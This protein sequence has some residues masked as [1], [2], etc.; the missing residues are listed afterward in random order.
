MMKVDNRPVFRFDISDFKITLKEKEK[1]D[2]QYWET[3]GRPYTFRK[4]DANSDLKN[5]IENDIMKLQFPSTRVIDYMNNVFN[6]YKKIGVGFNV[7][8]LKP[9]LRNFLIE[10]EV[11]ISG[12]E[13]IK[14]SFKGEDIITTND[15]ETICGDKFY[16]I[17]LNWFQKIIFKL[18]HPKIEIYI[19]KSDLM[20]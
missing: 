11:D 19:D 8:Y 5:L 9:K 16:T 2:I 4:E 12:L 1:Y 3:P 13:S 18:K 17:R 10:K 6:S 7:A 15:Q 14:F 20:E